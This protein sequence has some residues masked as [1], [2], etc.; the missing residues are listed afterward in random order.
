M[1]LREYFGDTYDGML[2]SELIG[3]TKDNLERAINLQMKEGKPDDVEKL[4]SDKLRQI[5]VLEH[6][7]S[8]DPGM[9]DLVVSN[10]SWEEPLTDPETG[11]MYERDSLRMHMGLVMLRN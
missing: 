8:N 10:I 6:A 11:L 9:G 5:K 1:Y 4:F 3:N 2:V 7:I